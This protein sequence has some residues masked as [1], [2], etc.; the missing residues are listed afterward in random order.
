M[1]LSYLGTAAGASQPQRMTARIVYGPPLASTSD[2]AQLHCRFLNLTTSEWSTSGCSAVSATHNAITDTVSVRCECEH[3]TEFALLLQDASSDG[4]PL[5]SDEERIVFLVAAFVYAIVM[6]LAFVQVLRILIGTRC[7]QLFSTHLLIVTMHSMVVLICFARM[8]LSA[9]RAVDA[10]H[11]TLTSVRDISIS[12][13]VILTAVPFCLH[14]FAYTML[15]FKW[16]SVYHF[17]NW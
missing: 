4:T 16:A 10:N 15:V 6:L 8:L 13:V 1:T 7:K 2:A 3:F 11:D 9:L 5:H 14:V 17:G 12:G